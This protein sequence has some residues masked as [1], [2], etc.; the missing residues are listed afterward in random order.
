M[1][2]YFFLFV[3]SIAIFFIHALYTKHAVYG[4]GNGYY[5]YTHALYFEKSL[6]FSQIYNHLQNFQG[7]N[8]IFSR[9]F[10]NTDLTKNGFI[11]Q[12]P[13]MIGTGLVWLPSFIFIS[14]INIVFNLNA[15]KFSII[16]ELGPGITGV[17]CMLGGLVFLEKYLL[18][19][20]QKRTAEL[21]IL[22]VFFATNV[23]YYTAFEPAL[24][25]QPAF[26]IVS[27]LLWWTAKLKLN[28]KKAIFLGI[29]GGALTIIRIADVILFIPFLFSFKNKVKF[30]PAVI[31]GF[32]IGIIPQ[33][34]NQ[35][36]QYGSPIVSPYL[37]GQSGVWQPK[38]IH[39]AEFLFSLKRGIFVWTPILYLGV[40]G[41]IKTKSFKFLAAIFL[42]WLIL[43][44][45]SSHLSAGFGQR[46]AFSSLPFLAYGLARVFNGLKTRKIFIVTIPFVL[47]NFTLLVGFYVLKLGR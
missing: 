38:F 10:W 14:L 42:S 13:Y 41:L 20:F 35:Y 43:S 44:S 16:Y 47:W 26:L 24:S 3:L 36:L 11:Q 12:N 17:L 2:K 29:L 19:F 45:W 27:F 28:Y 23:F 5:S 15:D 9:I 8:Y 39:F 21:T 33:V 30:L 1:K 32:L 25:H 6:N 40:W 34:T 31:A 18:L 4:D 22:A 46:L 37:N 7:R